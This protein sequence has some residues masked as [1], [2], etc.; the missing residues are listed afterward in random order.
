MVKT[1]TVYGGEL[2]FAGGWKCCVYSKEVKLWREGRRTSM[3][4][5][6]VASVWSC[7][8]SLSGGDGR[9]V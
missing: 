3:T 4:N 1:L 9:V 5:M 6:L 8:V 2:S 7:V